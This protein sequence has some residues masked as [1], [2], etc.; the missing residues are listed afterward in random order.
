MGPK[1]LLYEKISHFREGGTETSVA[2]FATA[3]P[4]FVDQALMEELKSFAEGRGR[5]NTRLCLHS[6]PSASDHDMIV[7]EYVTGRY[8]RPHK[9]E[10]KSET[11]HMLEGEILVVSFSEV[12]AVIASQKLGGTA[13]TIS[14]VDAGIYHTVLPL[15]ER[16]IYH[17]SKAGPFLGGQDSLP[18]DWSPDGSDAD[19][20]SAYI[21]TLLREL[22]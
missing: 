22:S 12:G 4:V 9:H 6:D 2:L 8:Y 21:D 13:A 3:S 10:I 15:T 20:A 18:A 1:H 11:I 7:L 5:V 17:E 16:V 19:E 14:R